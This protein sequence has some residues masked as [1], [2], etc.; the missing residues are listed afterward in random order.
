MSGLLT[1]PAFVGGFLLAVT[2]FGLVGDAWIGWR[3]RRAASVRR[4]QATARCREL[5][6]RLWSRG[7]VCHGLEAGAAVFIARAERAARAAETAEEQARLHV[8]ALEPGRARGAAEPPLVGD[9]AVAADGRLET[10]LDR[11]RRD[12]PPQ[13]AVDF[14]LAQ[15][16]WQ[17][18]RDH[19]VRLCRDLPD[20]PLDRWPVRHFVSETVTAARIADLEDLRDIGRLA[21]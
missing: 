19:Q 9:L 7:E 15:Q 5:R 14:D 3:R 10:L 1:D 20:D 2:V 6:R 21:R 11:L 4:E 16:A 18:Y 13:A 8:E 12:L 17:Q